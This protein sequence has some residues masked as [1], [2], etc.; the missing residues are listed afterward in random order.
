M[1]GHSSG[2]GAAEPARRQGLRAYSRVFLLASRAAV[3]L[4]SCMFQLLVR[5]P[6]RRQRW[7]ACRWPGTGVP[8]K[9]LIPPRLQL[10]FAS[11]PVLIHSQAVSCVLEALTSMPAVTCGADKARKQRGSRR[12][13]AIAPRRRRPCHSSARCSDPAFTSTSIE[14]NSTGS[15]FNSRTPQQ[16]AQGIPPRLPAPLGTSVAKL[17]AWLCVSVQANVV[18]QVRVAAVVRQ[19]DGGAT[20][21]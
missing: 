11:S 20:S 9:R 16:V 5:L 21:S 7:A 8:R 3:L 4:N 2:G 15:S 1:G 6:T 18:L 19:L 17:V 12:A 13:T 14:V 10:Q